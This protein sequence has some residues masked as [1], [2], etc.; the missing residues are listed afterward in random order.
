MGFEKTQ[1]FHVCFFLTKRDRFFLAKTISKFFGGIMVFHRLMQKDRHFE[2]YC[3]NRTQNYIV[4]SLQNQK[5]E[6]FVA[7]IFSK[8]T[9]RKKTPSGGK[10]GGRYILH[11]LWC[12]YVSTKVDKSDQLVT[13]KSDLKRWNAEGCRGHEE[14]RNRLDVCLSENA[15]LCSPEILSKDL[16]SKRYLKKR[17][18]QHW[19][20]VRALV[21]LKEK[22]QTD[23]R[24]F[25]QKYYFY[26]GR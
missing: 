6:I 15:S 12:F 22:L 8:K 1:K 17:A 26:L 2:A 9:H 11:P 14:K 10:F 5:V 23:G 16:L 18:G 25:N 21:F 20:A 7:K 3:K 24:V 13:R 19:Q 4:C